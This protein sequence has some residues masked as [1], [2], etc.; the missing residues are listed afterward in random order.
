MRCRCIFNLQVTVYKEDGSSEVIQTKNILIATGSEVT[1]FP[2]A[3]V[4]CSLWSYLTNK[5]IFLTFILLFPF[6][7]DEKVIIS[8]TGALSLNRVPEKMIL[9]GAGVI[10]VELVSTLLS[11]MAIC[12]ACRTSYCIVWFPER[13]QPHISQKRVFSSHQEVAAVG[14]CNCLVLPLSTLPIGVRAYQL[15]YYYFLNNFQSIY[16]LF[17]L[18]LKHFASKVILSM[19]MSLKHGKINVILGRKLNYNINQTVLYSGR[20]CIHPRINGVLSRL[21]LMLFYST[22]S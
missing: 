16:H 8:S 4:G 20:L 19:I 5:N 14:S 15:V 6:Q 2:G 21:P 22:L 9:I 1:P 12:T 3:E 10:G 18:W 13:S 17:M 11:V 7:V